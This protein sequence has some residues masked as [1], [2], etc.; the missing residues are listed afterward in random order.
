M[1]RTRIRAIGAALLLTSVV[2]LQPAPVLAQGR[3]RWDRWEDQR[4]RREDKRDRREDRWDRREDRYDR[5]EDR[6]DRREDRYDRREDYYDRDGY[7]DAA[8]YYRKDDRR[9]RA[10]RLGRNDR[11]YRGSD[12]RYYCKRS[13]GTAG[14]IIGGISGGVLGS[15]IAPRGSKTVGAIIGGGLGAIL[16]KMANDDDI[17]CR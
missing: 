17:V 2:G 14:L 1:T 8:R 5:R 9:Y 6:R 7:W 16:G 10:V 11:I 12:N 3:D 13:D 15:V 4:D